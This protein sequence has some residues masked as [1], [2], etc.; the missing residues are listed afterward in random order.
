[1][2]VRAV[3]DGSS[4]Q[5][6]A[7]ASNRRSQVDE[8]IAVRKV[9]TGR[10]ISFVMA[11]HAFRFDDRCQVAT[12]V[13]RSSL[14]GWRIEFHRRIERR[15]RDVRQIGSLGAAFMA[16]ETDSVLAGTNPC[17]GQRILQSHA[18]FV[19]RLPVE[20]RVGGYLDIER[21]VF[22]HGNFADDAFLLEVAD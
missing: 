2:E 19:E 11:P 12:E 16:S 1:M 20:D 3:E 5:R 18:V 15:K 14:L 10:R 7:V 17:P 9:E 13:D 6:S 4:D 8:L 21:A 22:A